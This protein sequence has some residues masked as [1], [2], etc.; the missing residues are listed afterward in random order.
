MATSENFL[1]HILAIV[2]VI[3]SFWDGFTTLYGTN[4]LL[5]GEGGAQAFASLLFA[6]LITTLLLN[7]KRIMSMGDTFEGNLSKILWF[8]ALGYDLYTAWEGNHRFLV[9]EVSG[10]RAVVLFGLTALTTGSPMLLSFQ[11]DDWF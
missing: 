6:V 3:A 9:T 8:L 10:G 4:Q 5:G 7:T 11:L 1:K 2:L